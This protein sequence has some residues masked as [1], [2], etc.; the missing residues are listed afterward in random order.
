M[1]QILRTRDILCDE[2]DVSNEYKNEVKRSMEEIGDE[3]L[4]AAEPEAQSR[5]DQPTPRNIRVVYDP[6]LYHKIISSLF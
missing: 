5:C 2:R 1:I 6:D 3:I 4:H